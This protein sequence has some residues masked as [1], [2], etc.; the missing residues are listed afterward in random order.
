MNEDEQKAE[1]ERE[2]TKAWADAAIVAGDRLLHVPTL[3]VGIPTRLCDGD[4]VSPVNDRASPGLVLVIEPGHGFMA[5][6]EN[7]FALRGG[8]AQFF[9]SM[10][11]GLAGLV[12]VAA[13]CA[14]QNGVEMDVGLTLL[15]SAMRMQ[16]AALEAS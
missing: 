15:L 14:E 4:W 11:Q 10:Q 16:M 8:A 13:R 6:K 12:A 1:R 3:T 2:E 9:D 5:K 7:F